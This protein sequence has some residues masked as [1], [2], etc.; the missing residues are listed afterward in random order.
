MTFAKQVVAASKAVDALAEEA[1]REGVTNV[2]LKEQKAAEEEL[3]KELQ[4]A[5]GILKRVRE[6]NQRLMESALPKKSARK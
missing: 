4:R 6:H 1:L 2:D 3:S 5:V